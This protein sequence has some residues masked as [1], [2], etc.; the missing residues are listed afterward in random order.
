MEDKA[1]AVPLLGLCRESSV[2]SLY[3]VVLTPCK[4]WC[5]GNVREHEA[6]GAS[7]GVHRCGVMLAAKFSLYIYIAW[8]KKQLGTDG[9]K[10][11]FSPK[12]I[13]QV[14]FCQFFILV[15][16]ISFG[17]I[18]FKRKFIF[19]MEENDSVLFASQLELQGWKMLPHQLERERTR[20]ETFW[21]TLRTRMKCMLFAVYLYVI[22][23]AYCFTSHCSYFWPE[24][25]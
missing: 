23:L 7:T 10:F 2:A 18:T 11:W 25:K 20:I 9:R 4:S 17:K 6:V 12:A 22:P 14:N 21:V 15:C 13:F 8:L 5:L 1:S 3:P 19:F 16:W 24:A